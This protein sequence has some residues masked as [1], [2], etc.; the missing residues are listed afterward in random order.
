[1]KHE[2]CFQRSET[3]FKYLLLFIFMGLVHV[4]SFY[5]FQNNPYDVRKRNGLTM[6]TVSNTLMI[7]GFVNGMEDICNK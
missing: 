4:I 3:L 6:E 2:K 1:M 7:L 5:I